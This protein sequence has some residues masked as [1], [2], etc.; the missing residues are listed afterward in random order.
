MDSCLTNNHLTLKTKTVGLDSLQ[1]FKFNRI[2]QIMFQRSRM[3][4]L[5]KEFKKEQENCLNSHKLHYQ[6]KAATI[7]HKSNNSAQVLSR[8]IQI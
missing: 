4:K 7:P 2:S 1:G 8:Q 3:S 6:M 5:S